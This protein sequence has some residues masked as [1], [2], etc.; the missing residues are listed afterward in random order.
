[1]TQFSVPMRSLLDIA[2][3]SLE[4]I[5]SQPIGIILSSSGEDHVLP[6]EPLEIS[7]TVNNKG[8]QSAIIDVYLDE[9][10]A[11]LQSWCTNTQTRLAL[12]P[13]QG[14]EVIFRFA[15]RWLSMCT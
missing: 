5:P 4:N 13:G 10:P 8:N 15:H 9:L 3:D 6:G 7:V 14:E 11:T 2:A 1:M 12:D